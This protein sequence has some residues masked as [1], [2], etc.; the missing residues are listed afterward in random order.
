ML[1]SPSDYKTAESRPEPWS[2]HRPAGGITR[3]LATFRREPLRAPAPLALRDISAGSGSGH[4]P[5]RAARD[6][7]SLRAI[8]AAA[9]GLPDPWSGGRL[10][11]LFAIDIAG[12]TDPCRDEHIQLYLREMIYRILERAFNGAGLPWRECQHEDR[13]DGALI[14]IPAVLP[15]D[16]LADPLP[17]RLHGLVRVHNRVSAERARVQVRAAAHIGMVYRDDHGFAGDSVSHL[18]RL[19]ESPRLKHLLAASGSELGLIASAYFYD[20]VICRHPTL[21]DPAAFQP[22]AVDLRHAQTTGWVQ[23][24]GSDIPIAA[25]G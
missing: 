3:L 5:V 21:V 1:S 8:T 23:L 15:V 10:C 20:N 7:S 14:I 16:A 4:S 9:A 6:R 12:F 18:C 24:L 19:L 22:V 11:G 2:L 13:G 25:A 17:E